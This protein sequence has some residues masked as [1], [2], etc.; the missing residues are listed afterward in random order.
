MGHHISAALLRGPFDRRIAESFDF[1]AIAL[2][3]EITLFPLHWAYCDQWSAKLG[4]SGF[5]SKRPLLNGR[6]VHH[7]IRSIAS[8]P[9]FAII[10]TDG[11]VE[12]AAAVYSGRAEVMSPKVGPLGGPINEALRCLGVSCDPG[13]D[14][15]D[16]VGL[17][18][19][20]NFDDLFE[21]YE[22]DS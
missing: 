13:K 8:E 7:I 12:Q 11:R 5:L 4:I 16:T 6:V 18:R 20:R 3:P 1:K 2:T 19:F 15:F 22:Q 14:E 17:G 21:S 10:E 9:L